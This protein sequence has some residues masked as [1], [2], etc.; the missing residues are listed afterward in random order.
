[1]I[2]AVPPAGPSAAVLV[3]GGAGYVGSF[4]VRHLLDAGY[5]QVVVFDNLYAGHRW[6][7]QEAELVEGDL[8]DLEAAG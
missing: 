4:I 7:V 1:M 5:Q 3:T 6:A 8:A 2:K